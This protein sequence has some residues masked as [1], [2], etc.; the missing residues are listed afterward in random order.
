M[1]G[2]L[3]PTVG[4]PHVTDRHPQPRLRADHRQRIRAPSGEQHGDALVIRSPPRISAAMIAQMRRQQSVHVIIGQ[5]TFQRRKFDPLQDDVALRVGHDVFL[6]PVAPLPIRVDDVVGGHAFGKISHFGV[7]AGLFFREEVLPV[8]DDQA[9]IADAG[10]IHTRVKNLGQDA[11]AEREPNAADP[12]D[13]SPDA[14]FAAR[15]PRRRTA[16]RAGCKQ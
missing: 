2:E 11:A 16:G 4:N 15:R 3:L 13:G 1:L 9:H 14:T 5:L 8:G 6:D 12:L 7:G 10:A